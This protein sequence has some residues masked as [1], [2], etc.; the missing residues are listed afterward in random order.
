MPVVSIV[1]LA[2][3]VSKSHD[4]TGQATIYR[5]RAWNRA[6]ARKEVLTAFGYV[7]GP[8]LPFV[9]GDLIDARDPFLSN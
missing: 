5:R 1:S 3:V 9:R 4:A 7:C 8:L 6:A 2:V